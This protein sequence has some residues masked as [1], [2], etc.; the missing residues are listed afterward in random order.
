VQQACIAAIEAGIANSA[1]DCADGGLAVTL[2]ECT[3]SGA[4]RLGATV[5]LPSAERADALLFGEAP[6]RII[7]T[8]NKNTIDELQKIAKQFSA[9]MQVIGH[10]GGTKLTI[11]DWIDCD[12]EALWSIW[13]TG[14]EKAVSS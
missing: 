7:L 12:V 11:N 6:S 10:V 14:F 2:A 8:I 5:T 13:S 9:P 4:Q 1:H 3:M